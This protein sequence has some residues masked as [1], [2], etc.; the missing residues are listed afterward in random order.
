MLSPTLKA[1]ITYL[2]PNKRLCGKNIIIT[3]GGHGL[4]AAMARKFVAEGAKV[5]ILGRN[6]ETLKRTA[7]EIGCDYI[8]F[9]VTESNGM[10]RML[11]E[12]DNVFKGCANVLVNN[13]GMSLHEGSIFNVTEKGY[14]A[15][16][17]VN[18]K[19]SYFLSQAFLHK[20]EEKHKTGN[21]LFV[22]SERG[23]YVDN[24][25]YGLTKSAINSLTQGLA[26]LMI[27]KGVRVNAVA[28]GV[29]ASDM[30][31]REVGGDMYAPQYATGRTY[32][33]EEV[34]EVACFLISDAASCIS[35]QIIYCDNGNS[36]NSYY[37]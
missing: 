8:K 32:Q 18:L 35:G 33:P 25:P 1:E 31:H 34:A 2:Y 28:P 36:V 10:E 37:K 20:L 27:K 4:G 7:A 29:T 11:N 15:Q 30:T 21:I 19:A 23:R 9:D 16:F 17:N 26:K 5:I 12:V 6:V 13:A 24:I 22:S 3:G 14:D